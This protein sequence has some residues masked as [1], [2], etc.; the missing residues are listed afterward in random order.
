MICYKDIS[1]CDSKT[2]GKKDCGYHVN[3]L[4]QEHVEKIGLPVACVDYSV[5]CKEYVNADAQE[6]PVLPAEES[7]VEE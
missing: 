3:N 2:C 6:V 4:N 1:F 5:Q 7:E